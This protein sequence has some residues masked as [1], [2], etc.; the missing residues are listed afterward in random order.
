MTWLGG[1]GGGGRGLLGDG[2]TTQTGLPKN[3][4]VAN[5]GTHY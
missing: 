2:Q 3:T 4:A 1:G 5:L